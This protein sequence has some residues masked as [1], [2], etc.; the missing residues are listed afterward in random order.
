M[1]TNSKLCLLGD[2]VGSIM[3][4]EDGWPAGVKHTYNWEAAVEDEAEDYT[5][6]A[7]RSS[8]VKPCVPNR[9]EDCSLLA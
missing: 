4:L 1:S 3:G 5:F 7:S 8:R 6:R 2:R 9:V